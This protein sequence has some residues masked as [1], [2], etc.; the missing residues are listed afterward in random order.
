MTYLLVFLASVAA[1]VC[2][3]M[4]FLEVGKARAARAATWSALIVAC[5]AFSIVEYA[6][7]PKY[8]LAAV[9]GCWVGTYGT[10][11]WGKK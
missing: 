10:M 3:T 9:F 4:Y 8:I 5:G 7:D 1:D 2:W 11:K 6:H